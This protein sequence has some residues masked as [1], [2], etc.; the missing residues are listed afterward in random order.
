MKFI[1]AITS[2]FFMLAQMG[3]ALPIA[4]A[5]P[6]GGPPGGWS[7]GPPGGFQGGPVGGPS[8][9][10]PPADYQNFDNDDDTHLLE[11]CI[12]ETATDDCTI[13]DLTVG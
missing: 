5:A 10:P 3:A 4:E 1:I 9:G 13:L 12:G 11:L 2:S 6:Q 8:G 7:A